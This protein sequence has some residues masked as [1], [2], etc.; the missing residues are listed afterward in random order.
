MS[1]REEEKTG[2]WRQRIQDAIKLATNGEWK[3]AI[4][5]NEA[6]L[7]VFP[8]DVDAYNRLG[9]AH[10]ELGE[11]KKAK[12]AYSKALEISPNNLIA[13]KNLDRIAL[14]KGS[15]VTVNEHRRKLSP[16]DFIAEVGR[17]GVVNL[18]DVAPR[19]LLVK[20]APGEEVF[21]DTRSQDSII[22]NFKNEY[23]GT[24]EPEHGLRLAKLHKGGNKYIAAAISID[25]D[26]VKVMIREIHQDESQRGKLS[27]PIKMETLP[28]HVNDRLLRHSAGEEEG[29]EEGD[30]GE[31]E[32]AETVPEGFSIYEGYAAPDDI[33]V[34]G[35]FGGQE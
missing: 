28:A 12:D 30:Y 2:I 22:K 25:G 7:K 6:I 24:I 32:E 26:K 10:M 34:V 11:Y 23:I 29:V 20:L 13:K 35:G 5:T 27:F 14:P 19:S 3:K 9:R 4:E 15:N 18:Q 33:R 17:A 16:K 1:E 21:L 31:A 8:T